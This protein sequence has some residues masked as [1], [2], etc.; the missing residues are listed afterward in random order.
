MTHQ[1]LRDVAY[2][3]PWRSSGIRQGVHRS[4]M[5]GGGGK[6]KDLAPLLDQPD[7]RR[8]AL[9]ASLTNPFEQLLVR[10]FEQTTAISVYALVD[11]SASMNFRG[12]THKLSLASDLVDA[13]A[14]CAARAGDKFGVIAFGDTV[15]PDHLL[16]ATRSASAHTSVVESLRSLQPSDRGTGGIEEAA[17][18]I[19]G[20]RKL[21]FLISDF[22]NP[23]AEID[24]MFACLAMHDVIPIELDDSRQID[25][26]PDWGL[27]RLNDL[28]T[29]A[30]RLVMM[31]PALKAAW[32]ER[33][34]ARKKE[35]YARSDAAGR[36]AFPVKDEVD[37]SALAAYLTY[38]R[39]A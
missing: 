39:R 33:Q 11:I 14:K 8:I 13:L 38:G 36:E 32:R 18:F 23:P 15:A 30:Q 37:W 26:L 24:R 5:T 35:L 1:P 16:P 31:R 9:R 20:R 28:E 19:A 21:V 4:R 25:D 3:L 34:T 29:N 10:R 2:R 7:P 27:L 12:R 6:F 17:G 22:L